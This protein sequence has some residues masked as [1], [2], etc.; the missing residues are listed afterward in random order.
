MMSFL[1][2]GLLA[3]AP[4]Y[5]GPIGLRGIK[6]KALV[7]PP[8]A[9]RVIPSSLVSYFSDVSMMG[10]SFVYCFGGKLFNFYS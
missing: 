2:I 6:L 5:I 7:S 8:K 1:W 4:L 9:P 10:T 3:L